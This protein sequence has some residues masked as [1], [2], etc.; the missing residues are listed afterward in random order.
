MIQPTHTEKLFTANRIFVGRNDA[1]AS[2]TAQC[3]QVDFKDSYKVLMWHG[4][5]GQG[6]SA[7]LREF[8]RIAKDLNK[9]SPDRIDCPKL[10]VAKVDF[11]DERLKRLDT[12]LYSIRSQLAQHRGF[13]FLAFDTAF[14]VYI[15][16]TRPNID[17]AKAFPELFSGEREVL[18]DLLNIIDGPVMIAAD[19]ASTAVPGANLVYKWGARL[20]G[21][22]ASW[23]K[24]RGNNLLAGVEDLQSEEL[25]QRLPTYLGADICELLKKKERIRPVI[26]FDTYEALWRNRGGRD[27][28]IDRRA[29]AWVRLLVQDSPGVLSVSYTHLTLPTI[30][31]V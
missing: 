15:K 17:V 3:S 24:K 30:Y 28:I 27:G 19:I 6:K 4:V 23:W 31:S 13:S 5:G 14:A 12:A 2:F 1:L 16:K 8:Q 10:V 29:D 20:T 22:F 25:L 11:E 18:M 7:L 26:L 21:R 9:E